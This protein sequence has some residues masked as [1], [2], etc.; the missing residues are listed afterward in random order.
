MYEFIAVIIGL[1]PVF[2]LGYV[3]IKEVI[4]RENI[5]KDINE[6]CTPRRA[7]VIDVLIQINGTNQNFS[8]IPIVKDKLNNKVYITYGKYDYTR[9]ITYFK[10]RIGNIDYEMEAKGKTF[11]IGDTVN[12]Y[13]RRELGKLPVEDPYVLV[14]GTSHTYMGKKENMGD[15]ALKFVDRYKVV[16]EV[17]DDFLN[18]AKDMIV[19]EG[20]INPNIYD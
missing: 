11:K 2:L 4:R 7:E 10:W 8:V 1:V 14:E 19:Y 5:L 12:L 6:N 3:I 20:Y 13:I 18:E 17:S 9:K 16:N 15:W